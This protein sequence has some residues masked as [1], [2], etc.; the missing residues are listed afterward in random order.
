MPTDWIHGTISKLTTFSREQMICLSLRFFWNCII[1]LDSATDSFTPR[2]P[3]WRS[4]K[5]RK[6][7]KVRKNASSHHLPTLCCCRI[8]QACACTTNC[9]FRCRPSLEIGFHRDRSPKPSYQAAK[10]R[11]PCTGSCAGSNWTAGSCRRSPGAQ[12]SSSESQTWHTFGFPPSPR[13]SCR[14]RW[15]AP[16]DRLV[17]I[18]HRR[19]C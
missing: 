6:V 11:G 12:R 19:L 1:G 15:L 14:S 13:S 9:C 8:R 17:I 4:R 7:R 18:F 2:A 10:D 3:Y 16:V 5:V